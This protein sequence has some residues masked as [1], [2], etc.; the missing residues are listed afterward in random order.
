ME[1]DLTTAAATAIWERAKEGLF[2]VV[3]D[4]VY[5]SWFSNLEPTGSDDETMRLSADGELPPY[6]LGT[7]IWMSYPIKYPSRQATI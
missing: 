3:G 5:E 7:I 4:K 2:S 6:G 1:T